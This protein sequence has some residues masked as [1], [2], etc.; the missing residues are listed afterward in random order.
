MFFFT[1]DSNHHLSLSLLVPLFNVK[2]VFVLL[3][4]PAYTNLLAILGQ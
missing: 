4:L 1:D 2:V 3:V